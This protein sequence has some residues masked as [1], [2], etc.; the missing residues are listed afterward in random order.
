MNESNQVVVWFNP[1]MS[2]SSGDIELPYYSTEITTSSS[3]YAVAL[4]KHLNSIGAKMYLE[5][6]GVLTAQSKKRQ[7]LHSS[8][9][10]LKAVLLLIYDVHVSF[11]PSIDVWKR[12]SKVTELRGA[13]WSYVECFPEGYKKGVKIFKACSDARIEG[14]PTWIID[15]CSGE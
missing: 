10:C 6:S 8:S 5:H 11:L 13:T 9:V 2:C 3:P 1:N 7:A 14:F 4:A 12:S 15:K